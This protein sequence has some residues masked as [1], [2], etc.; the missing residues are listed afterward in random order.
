MPE[1]ARVWVDGAWCGNCAQPS[2]VLVVDVEEL[3][4]RASEGGWAAAYANRA[5][6]EHLRQFVYRLARGRGLELETRS[7]GGRRGVLHVR[8]RP[9]RPL[10]APLPVRG[11]PREVLAPDAVAAAAELAARVRVE[12]EREGLR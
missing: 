4:R 5:E 3:V 10:P 11:E 6:R 1:V 12:L 2:R 8:L 7:E 9:G